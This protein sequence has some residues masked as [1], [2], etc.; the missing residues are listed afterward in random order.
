LKLALE[1]HVTE[2][3]RFLLQQLYDH[4]CFTES[5]KKQLEEEIERR[6]RP[7]QSEVAR[8]CTIP[9]VDRVTA[10]GLLAEIGLNMDQFPSSAH[11]ASWLVSVQGI[12]RA[13]GNV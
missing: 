8:L 1:G 4:L 11:L 12:S 5:K 6:M 2:H 9:G 7:F 13:P 3:H 10:W